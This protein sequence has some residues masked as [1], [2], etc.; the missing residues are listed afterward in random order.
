MN[1]QIKSIAI[2]GTGTMGSGIAALCANS[3]LP[4]LFLDL[5]SDGENRNA[6]AAA[7]LERMQGSRQPMLKDEGALARIQIGNYDDD[8][9]K[10]SECDWIIE[11]IVEDL[12]IKRT[13]LEKI[14]PLRSNGSIVTTNTSG[15]KLADITKGLGDRLARDIAVTHF[16][17][18]VQVMK[19][20][21]LVPGENTDNEVINCLSKFIGKDLGKG[22]VLAKD[23]VNF[24]A[25]RIGCFWLLNG[26]NSVQTAI[27]AG[28]SMEEIDAALSGPI[29]IPPTGLFGLLDLIG[30]DV[31]DLVAAN[32]RDHLPTEDV[33][34]E[35]A[36][37]PQVAQGMLARGQIGRKA[38]SGFYR[39]QKTED[40]E[41]LKE[42]FDIVTNDW[43]SSTNAV[44]PD[45]LLS[46]EGL[47]FADGPL[48]KLA[49]QVMGGTL[50]YAADLVPEIC[51]D[52]VNLDN[53][54]RWGFGWRQGPF[55]L[56]DVLG[57]GRI[58][59]RLK[60]EGRTIPKMLQVLDEAGSK[61]FYHND[62]AEYLGLDGAWHNI[63]K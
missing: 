49:W 34:L 46:A 59:D 47:L 58:I 36:N 50:L 35:Y 57:S 52:I 7:A 56:L 4:V 20:V 18:P 3:C 31:M 15:I 25:N 48:G 45:E 61:N 60:S 12:G 54:M 55:Q 19:L 1:R 5:P 53:A 16:F 13:F 42:T 32:L 2:C 28:C 17:N 51:D 41:R 22:V 11:A 62:G 23:T 10:I 43:R 24:I 37:L 63:K 26:L 44:L 21:E 40:G 39:M 14:E 33:G 30:L 38:G 9:A 27:N 8:L 6:I 29:G